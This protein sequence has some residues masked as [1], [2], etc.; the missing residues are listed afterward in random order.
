MKEITSQEIGE[1]QTK[2]SA[3]F[4]IDRVQHAIGGKLLYETLTLQPFNQMHDSISEEIMSNDFNYET[5]QTI[6]L[7]KNLIVHETYL[8]IYEFSLRVDSN[9]GLQRPGHKYDKFTL[10]CNGKVCTYL[11]ARG[12]INSLRLLTFIDIHM[13]LMDV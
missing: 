12:F 13:Y 1:D 10:K 11:F 3:Y 4:I 9:S 2:L 6:I 5:N 7:I 8:P